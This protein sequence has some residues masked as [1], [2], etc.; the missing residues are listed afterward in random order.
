MHFGDFVI[1]MRMAERGD[2]AMVDETVMQVRHHAGQ[3]S[4]RVPLSKATALRSQ[5]L[6]DYCAE[7][8]GRHPQDEAFVARLR[9]RIE[10]FHRLTMLWGW[11]VAPDGAEAEACARGLGTSLLDAG[12]GR[13]LGLAARV[14]LRPRVKSERVVRVIRKVTGVFGV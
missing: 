11:C 5:L 9:R 8:L 1:L 4:V 10:A 14:G 13:A 3:H 6:L 12:A 7:Y 2:V